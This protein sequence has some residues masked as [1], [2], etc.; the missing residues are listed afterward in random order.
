MFELETLQ[1]INLNKVDKGCLI[2][3][4]NKEQGYL[5]SI[6]DGTSRARNQLLD[7]RFLTGSSATRRIFRDARNA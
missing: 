6:I 1:G 7:G 4:T 5:M 3:N 2:Y